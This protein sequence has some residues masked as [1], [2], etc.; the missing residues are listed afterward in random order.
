[1]SVDVY[2]TSLG[3]YSLVMFFFLLWFKKILNHTS[4][5]KMQMQ[6]VKRTQNQQVAI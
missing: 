5:M 2:T 3:A 6:D 4:G 1:M